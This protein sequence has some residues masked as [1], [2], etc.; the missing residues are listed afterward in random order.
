MAVD[1]ALAHRHVVRGVQAMGEDSLLLCL[2]RA[3][4]FGH[5]GVTRPIVK[6]REGCACHLHGK[7]FGATSVTGAA[8]H[9]LG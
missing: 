7:L 2:V 9:G 3:G 4:Y 6:R 8:L 1:P 5:P